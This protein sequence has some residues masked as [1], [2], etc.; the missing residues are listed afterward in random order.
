MIMSL[1]LFAS[2]CAQK[3][4]EVK[5]EQNG[6]LVNKTYYDYDK[7]GNLTYVKDPKEKETKYEYDE[8]GRLSK[9]LNAKNE[10]T[11]YACNNLGN[12]IK[13][14]VIEY[15]A[16]GNLSKEIVTEKMYDEL[17]RLMKSL[18][19]YDSG[20]KPSIVKHDII[21]YDGVGN[22]IYKKDKKGNESN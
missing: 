9:V 2:G 22:V 20:N 13:T 12:L 15:D 1:M 10:P 16:Q 7:L 5:P 6:R 3:K 17:G 11:S 21:A 4:E 14:T 8:L 19:P 18:E